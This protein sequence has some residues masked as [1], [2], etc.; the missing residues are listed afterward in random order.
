M[1]E[2]IISMVYIFILEFFISSSGKK[3]STGFFRF[4]FTGKISIFYRKFLIQIYRG[5]CHFLLEIFNSNLPEKMLFLPDGLFIAV[6]KHA[7]KTFDTN[8]I[9]QATAR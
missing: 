9:S 3:I 8:V 2:G 1:L 5:K 7:S 6:Y 4:K